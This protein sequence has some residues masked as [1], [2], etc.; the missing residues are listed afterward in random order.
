LREPLTSSIRAM[1]ACRSSS[2]SS[3]ST[4]SAL[5]S[6]H[7]H[8]IDTMEMAL[9]QSINQLLCISCGKGG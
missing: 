5:H 4:S 1:Y 2:V 7:V 3:A 6:T 8:E 9:L